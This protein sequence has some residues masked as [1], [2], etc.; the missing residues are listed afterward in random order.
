VNASVNGHAGIVEIL[1][2]GG[3]NVDIV[4]L[5]SWLSNA[6]YFMLLYTCSL[7]CSM[8][9]II[10]HYASHHSCFVLLFPQ[11]GD[12]A[13]ACAAFAGHATVVELLLRPGAHLE[14]KNN[15]KSLTNMF[16][17]IPHCYF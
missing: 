13:L 14:A 1:L 9:L 10:H 8:P 3:A 12:T 15:V 2:Q 4:N 7:Y 5:V 6:I 11:H 17:C 16:H